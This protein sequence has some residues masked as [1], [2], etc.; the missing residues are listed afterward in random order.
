[1]AE[2]ESLGVL[3][4]AQRCLELIWPIEWFPSNESWGTNAWSWPTLA[5]AQ[6]QFEFILKHGP[7]EDFRP[8][9]EFRA[10]LQAEKASQA[11]EPLAGNCAP[12]S[13][14]SGKERATGKMG[15]QRLL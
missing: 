2:L 15:E 1:M 10:A 3:V 5:L 12:A 4:D 14:A 6:A 9:P 8:S 11:G 13:A 7:Q